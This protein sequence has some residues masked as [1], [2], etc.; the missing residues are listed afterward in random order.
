MTQHSFPLSVEFYI[1]SCVENVA[2]YPLISVNMKRES[3]PK[4][5]SRIAIEGVK[6]RYAT[7]EEE[8]FWMLCEYVRQ[9]K[10]HFT[11]TV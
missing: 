7:S 5:K 2:L 4:W 1:V 11:P 8:M 3:T 6:G 10:I 9:Y